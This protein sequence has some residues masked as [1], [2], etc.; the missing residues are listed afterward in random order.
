MY[1]KGAGNDKQGKDAGNRTLCP[2]RNF[3]Q[4]IKTDTNYDQP[5]SYNSS[6]RN[7]K[8]RNTLS[9]RF[10]TKNLLV[11]QYLK[12]D[13]KVFPKLWIK[14]R[15]DQ[16]WSLIFKER[17]LS[18]KLADR[19]MV[20][21]SKPFLT[22]YKHRAFLVDVAPECVFHSPLPNSFVF[23]VRLLKFCT[24]LLWHKMSILRQK[25][26]IISIMMSPW[27]HICS[28]EYL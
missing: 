10:N 1:K 15:F 11:K 20:W 5:V 24:E 2:Y 23:N 25:I 7:H 18:W 27:R 12:I 8:K 28:A 14:I 16:G 13:F 26:R 4:A 6:K 3:S 22:L 19:I 21:I 17:Q 9:N